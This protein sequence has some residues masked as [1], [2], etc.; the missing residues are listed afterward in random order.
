MKRWKNR[1]AAVMAV[2]VVVF[3]MLTG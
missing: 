1:I 2:I 3:V